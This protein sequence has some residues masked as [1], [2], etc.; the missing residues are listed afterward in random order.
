MRE[1]TEAEMIAGIQAGFAS[2]IGKI[3]QFTTI[4]DEQILRAITQGAKLAM[5]EHLKL[6]PVPLIKH[7]NAA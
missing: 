4:S 6:N 7:P 5:T 1:P 2:H 3:G